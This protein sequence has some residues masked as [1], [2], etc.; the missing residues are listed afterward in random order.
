MRMNAFRFYV[1]GQNLITLTSYTGY[2]PEVN[3][4]GS[5]SLSQGIDYGAYPQAKTILVGLNLKF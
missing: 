2:D 3:R 5:S 4:Y 1:S